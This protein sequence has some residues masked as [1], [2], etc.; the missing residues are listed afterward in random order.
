[1]GCAVE[2]VVNLMGCVFKR[3]EF[4]MGWGLIS[5]GVRFDFRWGVSEREEGFRWV[6]YD[7][8]WGLHVGCK[9]LWLMN[10]DRDGDSLKVSYRGLDGDGGGDEEWGWR[11]YC[12]T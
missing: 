9:K 1:M 6:V 4:S 12:H 8:G 2:L 7:M 5:D 10:G 11:W 3:R